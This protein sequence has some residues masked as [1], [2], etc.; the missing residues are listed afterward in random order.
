M[1]EGDGSIKQLDHCYA[2]PLV[3]HALVKNSFGGQFLFS[4]MGWFT[5]KMIK[6]MSKSDEDV[7]TNPI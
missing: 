1:E 3:A 4:Q 7:Q 6:M 5:K 2:P